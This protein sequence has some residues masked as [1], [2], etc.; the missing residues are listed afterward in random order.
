MRRIVW[1]MAALMVLALPLV[2]AAQTQTGSVTGVVT[3]TSGGV[4]PGATVTLKGASGAAKTTVTDGTGHYTITDVAPGPYELTI[5]MSGFTKQV[6]KIAVAAGQPFNADIKLA[7]GA[8]AET[9]QVTGSLIPRPTLEAMAPVT[10]MDVQEL[11][12]RG[13]NRVEDILISLP[14][15]FAAQNSTRSNGASGTATVNLRYLGDNRTQVLLDGRRLGAGDSFTIAPDL[16]FVPEALVKRV[17]ILTGG[18]SATYGVDAVAGVVNFILDSSFEGV[19]GGFQ[20]TGYQHNNNNALAQQINKT[21]GFTAPTGSVWNGAPSDFNVAMGGKFNER[22][23][24]ASVYFDYRT[25]PAIMKDQRDYTNCSVSGAPVLSG[26][27]CGGSSTWQWGRFQVFDP[28]GS[29]NKTYV[30]DPSTG[31]TLRPRVGA[32][33]YNYAPWNYMQRNDTRWAGGGFM[34]Y[35]VNAR[36]KVYGEVMF[37]DDRSDAQIAPSADFNGT[38]QLNCDNPMLSAQEESE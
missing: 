23:G 7:I 4:L 34:N 30:L 10:T 24:H 3:D 11:E 27:Y 1:F 6:S 22:K 26:P 18:A 12:Y 38:S 16:N 15:V 17:D 19:R 13:M 31:N 32:D 29:T 8:Q 28:S 33:V 5:E 35:D 14:Q 36:A 9:V 20:Q 37:M 25:T 21:A 2:G